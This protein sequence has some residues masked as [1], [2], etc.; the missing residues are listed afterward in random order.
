MITTPLPLRIVVAIFIFICCSRKA[1]TDA[2]CNNPKAHQ[3]RLQQSRSHCHGHGVINRHSSCRDIHY[4]TLALH[5]HRDHGAQSSGSFLA[6]AA[7]EDLSS[8]E[9]ACSTTTANANNNNHHHDNNN[10]K[11]RKF[12][13]TLTLPIAA[14][15]LISQQATPPMANAVD[16]PLNLKGTFWETGR[17]YEKSAAADDPLPPSSADD[18]LAVLENAVEAL[19]SPQLVRAIEEGRYGAASRSLRGGLISESKLRIAANALMDEMPEDDEAAYRS[20]EAFRVFLRCLDV[21]D[22]EV[23]SASRPSFGGDV[24]G[25]GLGGGGGDPRMKILTRLGEAEDSMKVVVKTIRSGF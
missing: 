10:A 15:L 21:L 14:A 1:S 20:R 16:N 19:R 8:G 9:A 6:T 23:E 2:L 18:F 3:L 11:R 4:L 25:G 12:L 13:S 22:A 24:G 7:D 5:G 17:L